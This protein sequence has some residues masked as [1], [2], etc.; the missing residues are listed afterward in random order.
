VAPR[1]PESVP[2]T[3]TRESRR[4]HGV[5]A[6]SRHAGNCTVRESDGSRLPKQP[7]LGALPH[8]TGSHSTARIDH[9]HEAPFVI[10]L[11]AGLI[12]C[13]TRI[14]TPWRSRPAMDPTEAQAWQ[15][16][17]RGWSA[18]T[19]S[20]H[21]ITNWK[22]AGGYVDPATVDANSAGP[23]ISGSPA[24]GFSPRPAVAAG[25][26]GIPRAHGSVPGLPPSTASA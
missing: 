4:A 3:D 11:A 21:P 13:S 25:Q 22:C 26:E 8:E 2:H 10:T 5:L 12:G 16:R 15:T 24:S 20:E 6:G 19:S 18:A 1:T 14:A 7:A 9:N 23:P 17:N